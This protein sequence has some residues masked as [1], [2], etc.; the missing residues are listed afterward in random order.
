MERSEEK[1]SEPDPGS[2]GEPEAAAEPAATDSPGRGERLLT[3]TLWVLLALALV[4]RVPDLSRPLDRQFD[5]FQGAFFAFTAINYERLDLEPVW[6]YPVLN[7]DPPP[8]PEDG[9]YLYANHPPL[10]PLMLWGTLRVLGPTGWSEAWR[11][12]RAPEGLEGP[13]RAPFLALNALTALLLASALARAG[14]RRA[15]WPAALLALLAP[16]ALVYA[17]LVNYE[18]PSLAATAAIAWLLVLR[19]AA[20]RPWHLIA[21]AAAGAIAAGVTYMPLL[22]LP[23][24]ALAA[25]SASGRRAWPGLVALGGGALVTLVLHALAAGRAAH[26]VGL[27]GDSL[28][29]RV[30]TLLGPLLD[31]SLP[32]GSWAAVQARVLFDHGGPLLLLLAAAGVLLAAAAGLAR[33]RTSSESRA[34]S[35][36]PIAPIAPGALAAAL[37]AGGLLVQLAFYRHTGDPQ[38]PFALHLVPGLAAFAGLAI[39]A[40]AKRAPAAAAVAL[41]LCG[42]AGLWGAARLAAP[43]RSPAPPDATS[44]GPGPGAAALPLPHVLGLELGTLVPPGAVV[45]YPKD[46]GLTPA[47]SFYAWRTLLALDPADTGAAE[48]ALGRLG[49]ARAARY[50]AVPRRGPAELLASVAALETDLAR[51][52]PGIRPF[53]E[54]STWRLWRLQEELP[55]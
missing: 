8:A 18:P 36:R 24:L 11:E 46:L 10:M 7:I 26:A 42:L 2:E 33:G 23:G 45:L 44:Q 27:E 53:A 43:W 37:L 20:P 49:M 51:A 28:G 54:G 41:A 4:W 52:V 22:F 13:L 31:G 48:L 14:E 3:L 9:W 35:P 34:P 15:A 5:G 39:G 47:T 30:E 55:R 50:L 29:E 25:L 6:P 17:G 38:E 16:G 21:L 32:F 19:S 1:P 12:G 40:L